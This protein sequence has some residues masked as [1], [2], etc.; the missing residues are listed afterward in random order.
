M[1]LFGTGGGGYII[2]VNNEVTSWSTR[3][4]IF[5]KLLVIFTTTVYPRLELNYD[6]SFAQRCP[7]NFQFVK[8][9]FFNKISQFDSAVLPACCLNSLSR[10]CINSIKFMPVFLNALLFKDRCSMYFY[11]KSAKCAKFKGYIIFIIKTKNY[12]YQ[13]IIQCLW[14]LH[15]DLSRKESW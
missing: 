8:K 14:K 4:Y 10:K 5:I 1:V 7:L 2:V 11:I 3:H 13:F 15:S 9:M 6:F 12:F